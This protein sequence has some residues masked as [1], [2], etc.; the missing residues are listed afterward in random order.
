MAVSYRNTGT[1]S[2][3]AGTVTPGLPGSFAAGDMHVLHVMTRGA[4]PATVNTPTGFIA[5]TN[6]EFTG[7]AGVEAVDAG[8][9]RVKLFFRIAV[10]GDT[11]PSV[12][13]G[14][15][16]SVAVAYISGY[17]KAANE[18]WSIEASGGSDNTATTT[19]F[20]PVTA[21]NLM[22]LRAGDWLCTFVGLNNDTGTLTTPR[23]LT[24]AGATLGTATGRISKAA[25]TIGDNGAVDIA[26]AQV[27][28]GIAT[29]A[30]VLTLTQVGAATNNAGAMAFYRLR[31]GYARSYRTMKEASGSTGAA[32]S[33]TVVPALTG[34]SQGGHGR[35]ILAGIVADAQTITAPAGWATDLSGTI[36]TLNFYLFRKHAVDGETSWTFTASGACAMAW[37]AREVMGITE[38]ATRDVAQSASSA[39]GGTTQSSGTTG[40]TTQ[41]N[42]LALTLFG[43]QLPAGATATTTGY[44]NSFTEV[45]DVQTSKAAGNNAGLAVAEKMLAAT[46]TVESTATWDTSTAARYGTAV[47]Y[48]VGGQIVTDT[49]AVVQERIGNTGNVT[50]PT[51]VTATLPAASTVGPGRYVIVMLVSY[52]FFTTVP[53]GWTLMKFEEDVQGQ[54]F[55]IRPADGLASWVFSI[56]PAASSMAWWAAEIAGVLDIDQMVVGGSS[57][58]SATSPTGNTPASTNQADEWAMAAFGYA[59]VT[60]TAAR[61][62]SGYTNSF[63]E[64]AETATARTGAGGENV[65]LAIA[66]KTLTTTGVQSCTVTWSGTIEPTAM[67]VTFKIIPAAAAAPARKGRVIA[68]RQA[69]HRA[70]R[71]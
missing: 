14:T 29:A 3:A 57:T 24:C 52:Q 47:T 27:T 45:A 38:P 48:K 7:G 34:G 53:A 18:E 25:T 8:Q 65:G 21:A 9:V 23:T 63:V 70:S 36:G 26:N 55:Y 6:G 44:T 40:T 17:T 42:T 71:W 64:R 68:S 60:S 1:V 59:Q 43:W 69:V 67:L 56:S 22:S 41:A 58:A 62:A 12:T 28:A 49:F 16:P 20:G 11:A 30:P 13:F 5:L 50:E 35:H 37:W 10:A 61:T 66:D 15:V 19:S 39:A 46:G 54:Y 2:A 33:T 4:T 51:S 32:T 31:A